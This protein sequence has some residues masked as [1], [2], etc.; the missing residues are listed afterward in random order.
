MILNECKSETVHNL[1][2]D[3]AYEVCRPPKRSFSRVPPSLRPKTQRKQENRPFASPSLQPCTQT[4]H[5]KC[6]VH[7]NGPSPVLR[8][9]VP[10]PKLGTQCDTSA[11]YLRKQTS[12]LPFK[13][14]TP[15]TGQCTRMCT[16]GNRTRM[17]D[18]PGTPHPIAGSLNG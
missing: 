10:R 4:V 3:D 15:D 17:S 16:A 11:R 2:S 14:P 12:K 6:A 18:L 5:A 1:H 8:L 9:S 7:P 13:R